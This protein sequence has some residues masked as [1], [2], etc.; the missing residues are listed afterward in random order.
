[1]KFYEFLWNPMNFHEIL[2]I[3][4]KSY[5]FSW[6][7]MNFCKILPKLMINILFVKSYLFSWNITNNYNRNIR[8]IP[9]IFVN[10]HRFSWNTNVFCEIPS[11][12]V[13]SSNN[14]FPTV[15]FRKPRNP[16]NFCL[17]FI[18]SHTFNKIHY[19][20]KKKQK[21]QCN[22]Q[23]M[24]KYTCSCAISAAIALDTREND[25]TGERTRERMKEN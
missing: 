20:T 25:R 17:I 2:W 11:I 6:N 4:V 7:P 23:K 24:K 5:Q 19:K 22:V 8:E 10:F 9:S 21:T 3:F 14:P 16:S 15:R 12:F 1:M 13:K 18:F